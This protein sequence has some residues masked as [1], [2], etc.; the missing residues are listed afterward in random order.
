MIT[1]VRKDIKNTIEYL[2]DKH[3]FGFGCGIQGRR[4]TYYLKSWGLEK[5]TIAFIDNS[6]DKIGKKIEF[7]GCEFSIISLEDAVRYIV[8]QNVSDSIVFLVT[9]LHYLQIYQ[10]IE[11]EYPQYNFICMSMAE[12]ASEQ[13]AVSQYDEVV[14]QYDE[15]VI[16]PIIHYAWF[17]GKKP[18]VIKR[19]IENWHKLCPDYKIIEWNENNYDVTNN[20][21][22]NEAYSVQKW[23]FVP[24]YLRLDIIYKYGGIYLD[25][26]IELIKKPDRLLYQDAFACCDA[27]L[28]MNL[29][30]GFGAKKHCPVIKEIRDYYNFVHFVLEDGTIDSTSCNSHQLVQLSEWD[31]RND[32]S[33]QKVKGLNIYPMCFQGANCY[34]KEYKVS[35]KTFWIHYGNMSWF[36]KD[37]RGENED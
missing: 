23:G 13:L 2:K 4:A 21:Y 6:E 27:S 5:N 33:L 26:D 31:Y 8:E 16:P 1:I 15:P 28:T 10:Q 18:D 25:T 20:P 12:I 30:S 24:D 17:G 37:C 34:T 11:K 9:S 22:M 35:E 7:L 14:M 32:D 3:I 19:N 36:E 29:G